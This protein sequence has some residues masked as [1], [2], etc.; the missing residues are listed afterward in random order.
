MKKKT[1]N[2][3]RIEETKETQQ[4]KAM[5]NLGLDPEPEKGHVGA[6]ENFIEGLLVT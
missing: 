1:E 4:L 6:L 2:L 5:H 3:S